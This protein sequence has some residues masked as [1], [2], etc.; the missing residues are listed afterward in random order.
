MRIIGTAVLAIVAAHAAHAFHGHLHTLSEHHAA[1][2]LHAAAC[3]APA[4][5]IALRVLWPE[6]AIAPI[7]PVIGHWHATVNAIGY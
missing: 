4:T 3:S 2:S 1:G 5:A 6:T 7:S